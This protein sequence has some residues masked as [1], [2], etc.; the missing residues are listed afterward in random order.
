MRLEAAVE[1]GFRA[2]VGGT[3]NLNCLNLVTVVANFSMSA[4][5]LGHCPFVTTKVTAPTTARSLF[6]LFFFDIKK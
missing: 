4:D 5:I 3:Q 6:F 2:S 1:G